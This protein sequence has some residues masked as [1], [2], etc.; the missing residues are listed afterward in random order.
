LVFCF[1]HQKDFHL[2]SDFS[3]P[4]SEGIWFA[5]QLS[6]DAC[7]TQAILNILLNV[8]KIYLGEYLTT[9]KQET[10]EFDAVVGLTFSSWFLT[11][12]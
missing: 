9:F 5:N 6:D 7:A 2:R 1:P 4:A 11:R 8:D 3:D 10:A 12:I